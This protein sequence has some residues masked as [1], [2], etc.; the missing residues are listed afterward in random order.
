LQQAFVGC[1]FNLGRGHDLLRL[2]AAEIEAFSA[3]RRRG[4]VGEDHLAVS[5]KTW[6]SLPWSWLKRE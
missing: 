2:D 5:A 1:R 6:R 4:V 3:G